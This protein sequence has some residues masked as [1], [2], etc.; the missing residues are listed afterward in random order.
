MV[1]RW[2][3]RNATEVPASQGVWIAANEREYL[4]PVSLESQVRLHMR[5]VLRCGRRCSHALLVSTC[6]G[7]RQGM[8]DF[9]T[10]NGFPVGHVDTE[11]TNTIEVA[12]A[13][14]RLFFPHVVGWMVAALA[15]RLALVCAL[16]R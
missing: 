4:F 7:C 12:I 5:A 10:K 9:V 11:P 16:R 1:D 3:G 8:R 14:L 6:L 13:G 2:I 15:G